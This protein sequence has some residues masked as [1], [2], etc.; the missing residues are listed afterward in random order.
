MARIYVDCDGCL[1]SNTLDSQYEMV[2]NEEG[3]KAAVKWYSNQ[4]VNN[5]P[6]NKTLWERLQRMYEQGHELILWTNRDHSKSNMTFEN[7]DKHGI[8]FYFKM[9]IFADGNKAKTGRYHDGVVFDND[10]RNKVDCIEFNYIP[11]FT[12]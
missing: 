8:L 11:T 4:Y 10:F 1:L 7:L 9:F 5:L 3:K 6:L 2:L 12:G